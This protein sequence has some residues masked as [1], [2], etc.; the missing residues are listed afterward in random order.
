MFNSSFYQTFKL[1]LK[2]LFLQKLRSG[3]AALGIIIGTTAVIWLVAFGEGASYEAQQRIKELG[4]TNIIIR[5][6]K[7]VSTD[8]SHPRLTCQRSSSLQPSDLYGATNSEIYAI[9]KELADETCL[10]F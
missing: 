8:Q 3:L 10:T 6:V 5:N 4:A 7:P 9:K 1:G 2:S